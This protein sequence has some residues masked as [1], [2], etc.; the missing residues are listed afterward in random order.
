MTELMHIQRGPDPRFPDGRGSGCSLFEQPDKLTIARIVTIVAASFH[1]RPNE[2]VGPGRNRGFTWAR[3]AAVWLAR[4]SLPASTPQIGRAL[5]GR[6]HTTILHALKRVEQRRAIDP[7]WRAQ[8]DD[9]LA[10]CEAMPGSTR[11][12]LEELDHAG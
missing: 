3:H 11:C 5:G 10:V 1:V 9:L 12:K 6:D 2:I 7:V 8:L 4:N